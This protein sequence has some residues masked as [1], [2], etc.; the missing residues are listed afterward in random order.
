M[1]PDRQTHIHENIQIR[2][3]ILLFEFK[4]YGKCWAKFYLFYTHRFSMKIPVEFTGE[5][6]YYL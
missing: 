4:T 1:E 3:Y 5:D 2:E 6:G